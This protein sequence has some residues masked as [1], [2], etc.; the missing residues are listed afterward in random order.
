MK[1]IKQIK[2][3]FLLKWKKREYIK[4]KSN[5]LIIELMGESFLANEESIFG[6]VNYNYLAKESNWYLSQSLNVYDMED[7]PKIWKEICGL[8]GCINSNYGWIM[9]NQEN[10]NQ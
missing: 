9:F 6:K 7:P 5:V 4:D 10:H 1:T 8:D 2:E 3:S